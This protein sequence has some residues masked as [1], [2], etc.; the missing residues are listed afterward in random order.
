MTARRF[1]FDVFASGVLVASTNDE[2]EA[3]RLLVELGAGSRIRCN[4]LWV[5]IEVDED[6]HARKTVKP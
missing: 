2:H 1:T 3:A 6:E 4:G 5:D